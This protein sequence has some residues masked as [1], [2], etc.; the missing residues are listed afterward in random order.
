[1][2]GNTCF[3]ENH[4][5]MTKATFTRIVLPIGLFAAVG[6][7]IWA[8]LSSGTTPAAIDPGALA[9]LRTACDA[10]LVFA[11]GLL[12]AGTSVQ[13]GT[14][15]RAMPAPPAGSDPDDMGVVFHY[16]AQD[17]GAGSFGFQLA[18]EYVYLKKVRASDHPRDVDRDRL[19]DVVA[20]P[21]SITG[22]TGAVVRPISH[23]VLGNP[24]RYDGWRNREALQYRRQMQIGRS[25][26][27]GPDP[28]QQ[29]TDP[30]C[31]VFPWEGEIMELASDNDVG[32]N[33]VLNIMN[34]ATRE[35]NAFEDDGTRT[36]LSGYHHALCLHFDGTMSPE[37][38]PDS[39]PYK[40]RA[41]NLGTLCPPRCKLYVKSDDL[42]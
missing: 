20:I 23:G 29:Y 15:K 30:E 8:L 32:D 36:R 11:G 6:V 22:Y 13:W 37:R 5:P 1:M 7:L 17:L 34:I 39:K 28:F 21:E 14:L 16:G 33:A 9:Q 10:Q 18:V 12:P 27:G 4:R 3:V 24:V 42:P 2:Q 31:E 19:Y 38:A 25:I 26:S 40:G 35:G 41:A